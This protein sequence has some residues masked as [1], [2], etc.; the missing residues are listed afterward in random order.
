MSRMN[1]LLPRT[2]PL[3]VV[4]LPLLIGLLDFALYKIGGNEATISKVLLNN[5]LNRPLVALST[6]YS[7]GVLLGHLFFPVYGEDMPPGYEVIA[8]MLV[9]LSPTFYALVI[10]GAG[11]AAAGAHYHALLR[12]GQ[13]LLAA[14]MIAAA[15]VG[16]VAGKF[17]LP[18]HLPPI[19]AEGI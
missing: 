4:S 5:A 1:E 14:Y 13:P 17:V 16:G 7:V 6:A 18:Q 3:L 2:A 11:G 12:G 19:Q 10:I 9:A 15:T 8:R